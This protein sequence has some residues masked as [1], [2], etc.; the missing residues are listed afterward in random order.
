MK[1]TISKRTGE[2]MARV[3]VTIPVDL[4]EKIDKKAKKL[5]ISRSGITERLLKKALDSK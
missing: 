3:T 1:T 4:L 2:K 5:G